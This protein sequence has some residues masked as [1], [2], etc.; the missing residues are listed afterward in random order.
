MLVDS[1]TH[2]DA[3][4]FDDDREEVIQRA[5][6]SSLDLLI[7][8]A[9]ARPAEFSIQR[10]LE[11]LQ[12]YDFI[13]GAVGVHP[14]DAS[15]VDA[16]Y[17]QKLQTWSDNPKVVLWGEIGLDYYYDHSPRDC[18][19]EVFRRQLKIAIERGLPVSI[20][21]RDA[22]PDL[23]EIL[24]A[25]CDGTGLKGMLHSFTGS[26][27]DAQQCVSMGFFISFS[28]IVTFKNASSLRDVARELSLDQILV[29][30]DAP[31][32]APVPHRG[33][34]NEPAF[35]A[36][37]AR[38]LADTMDVSF[39]SLTQSVSRNLRKVLGLEAVP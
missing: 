2:L 5:R 1:H 37:V 23:M 26:K 25:E 28:G 22:W 19:R 34:R 12:G 15:H 18:Q 10:T 6:D 4:E 21:C 27:E 32:L 16:S 36:D 14:H 3:P 13:Y 29:E 33:R 17:L 30:T 35:V 39:E 38:S 11:L 9:T 24:D 8:I 20:H 7:N 31:Y